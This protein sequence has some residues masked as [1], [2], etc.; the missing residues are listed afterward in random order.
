VIE[1]LEQLGPVQ[2]ALRVLWNPLSNQW[3]GSQSLPTGNTKI[4]GDLQLTGNVTINTVLGGPGAV[5]VIYNG[6]LDNGYTITTSNGSAATVAFS[7]DNS[8]TYTHAP[9]GGGK[10]DIA[11]PTSDLS[12]WKGV[13]M[14]Q[15]PKLTI[16]VDISEAGNT[17]A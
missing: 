13:A 14:Y 16:G 6:Q 11:A 15:D 8:G 1:D 10:I 4:C 12:P 3:T 17:P 7:G 5:L 9:T 2:T